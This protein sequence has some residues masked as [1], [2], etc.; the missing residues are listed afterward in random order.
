MSKEFHAK[1]DLFKSSFR[2]KY[3]I[4]FQSFNLKSA[5]AYIAF[6]NHETYTPRFFED[7]TTVLVQKNFILLSAT[8]HSFLRLL[9]IKCAFSETVNN[10][11][12]VHE[13]GGLDGA[14]EKMLG[15]EDEEALA[16]K[17][18]EVK[19]ITGSQNPNGDAKIDIGSVEKVS[20]RLFVQ[21]I[22]EFDWEAIKIRC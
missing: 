13:N 22:S 7:T 11:N 18:V 6:R 8:P 15:K 9:L 12:M 19:F 2:M 1:V 21:S 20:C 10:S 4:K 16:L 14:D 3:S 5:A 17:S